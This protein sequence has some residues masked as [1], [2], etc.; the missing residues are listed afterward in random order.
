MSD[1]DNPEEPETFDPKKLLLR[2]RNFVDSPALQGTVAVGRRALEVASH[3]G[4]ANLKGPLAAAGAAVGLAEILLGGEERDT[5]ELV[6]DRTRAAGL[7]QVPTFFEG[8]FSGLFEN[9]WFDNGDMLL[10]HGSISVRTREFKGI[11]LA[12]GLE[13][14]RYTDSYGPWVSAEAASSFRAT[15]L[16]AFFENIEG[17]VLTLR[18]VPSRNTAGTVMKV[19]GVAGYENLVYAGSKDPKTFAENFSRAR[20]HGISQAF[21]LTGPPGSGKTS[22]TYLVARALGGRTLVLEPSIFQGGDSA[23]I[24]NVLTSVRL[25]AP[26]VVLLD[27]VNNIASGGDGGRLLTFVDRLRR[28]NPDM[29]LMSA[30]NYPDRILPS[31]RRPGRLGRRLHFEAPG[32][33]DRVEIIKAYSKALGVKRDLTYLAPRMENEL[34]TPDYIKDVCEKGLIYTKPELDEYLDEVLVYLKSLGGKGFPEYAAED[35]E[36]DEDDDLQV[37]PSRRSE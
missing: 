27:D 14:D 2:F 29:L 35:D 13:N 4:Q 34:F 16:E 19:S 23:L 20:G 30:T 7:T 22:F 28:E 9:G 32:L 15:L 25:L 21:F 10:H 26:A 37:V 12:I 18:G 8:V 1:T 6:R 36:D 11:V 24:N 5:Y 31:M 17:D 3:L 33:L